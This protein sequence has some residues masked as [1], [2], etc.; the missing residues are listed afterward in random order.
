MPEW[1]RPSTC[2]SAGNCVE[3]AH[4]EDGLVLVRDTRRPSVI[5]RF[6]D[7]EWT[8]FTAGVRA[9]EFDT[10]TERTTP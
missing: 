4:D 5:L 10:P 9:G 1:K 3:V 6:T 7:A 2:G 8:A